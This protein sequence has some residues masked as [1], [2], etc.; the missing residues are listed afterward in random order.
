MFVDSVIKNNMSLL[1]EVIELHKCGR[2]LPDSYV[3]DVDTFV[4]NAKIMLE[5][6]R[7]LKLK[8]YFMLKQVGRNPYLAKK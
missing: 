3:I 2:I 5:K 4:D 7:S 8:M 6:A 1:K